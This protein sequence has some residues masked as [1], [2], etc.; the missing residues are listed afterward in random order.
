MKRN[1]KKKNEKKTISML[2]REIVCAIVTRK[3]HCDEY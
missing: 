1:E 2:G 3:I